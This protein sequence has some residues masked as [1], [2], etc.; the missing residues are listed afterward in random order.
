MRNMT[1]RPNTLVSSL[2]PEA[3]PN[4]PSLHTKP[5]PL[6]LRHAR[7]AATQDLERLALQ[8]AGLGA[9]V[10]VL[11]LHARN[12][13]PRDDGAERHE[14]GKD[15]DDAREGHGV[16]V[17]DA[18][19]LEEEEGELDADGAELARAGGDAVGGA[20][21]AGREDLGGHDEGQGVW[22]EGEAELHEGVGGD[23]DPVGARVEEE[24]EEDGEGEEGQGQGGEGG[25]HGAPPVDAVDEGDDEEGAEDA[26]DAGGE[27]GVFGVGQE[28]LADRAGVA[29]GRVEEPRRLGDGVLLLFGS[30]E[31]GHCAWVVE[32]EAVLGGEC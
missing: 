10:L 1:R 28:D 13:R 32:A 15:E 20:A 27:G 8:P 29:E 4:L 11:L 31:F 18:A 26:G 24:V 7:P 17:L 6:L 5:H 22:A 23:E 2:L 21:V 14:S 3:L 12:P 19:A 16:W 9:F 25:D 30:P